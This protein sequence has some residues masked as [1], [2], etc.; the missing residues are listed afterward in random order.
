MVEFLLDYGL[1]LAKA[2]TVVL[3]ILAVVVGIAATARQV[4]GKA[5]G[6]LH[7]RSLNE[8]FESMATTLKEHILPK[9]ELKKE[10]KAQKAAK[11]EKE[12][13]AQLA[14]D[15][16]RRRVF[17]LKFHGDIRATQVADLR[18]AVTAVLGIATPDDEIVV[19]LESSG[20]QV[21]SYGLAASQLA[22]IRDRNIP[23]TIIV[24][25]VAASGGYLMA[26]VADRILAA[27]FAIVGS[28]GVVG[29]LPNFH[30]FLKKHDIDFELMTA[31]EYKRTLTLFGENT[32][33]ARDKFLHELEDTHQLFKEFIQ[34]YRSRLDLDQLATGEYWYG[35]RALQLKLIDELRTSDDYLMERSKDCDLYEVT[36]TAK[37][38]L[39]ER[40]ES[41]MEGKL[42]RLVGRY[43]VPER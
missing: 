43:F 9:R 21:H 8:E 6:A 14:T 13:Q 26:C 40:V 28:I 5:K 19:R 35:T 29:Q 20:G 2:V 37:K 15:A 41:Y 18:E 12:K 1:F 23:L 34:D 4:R 39:T 11:K 38:R 22:R 3:A 36:Y 17:V 32:D 24:D 42:H 27:P 33:K 30:R 7:V 31:G 25:K 16:K 10:A